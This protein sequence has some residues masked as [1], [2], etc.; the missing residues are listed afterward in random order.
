LFCRTRFGTQGF[1]LAKQALYRLSHASSH[2]SLVILEMETDEW[3][4]WAGLELWSFW[5]QL[6]KYLGFQAW[7]TSRLVLILIFN[8]LAWGYV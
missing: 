3:F 4:A 5:S 7:A 2:F 1:M 8:S 6:P